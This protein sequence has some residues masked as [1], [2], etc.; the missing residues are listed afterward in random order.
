MKRGFD[1][2]QGSS[3][4]EESSAKLLRCETT[5]LWHALDALKAGDS[6]LWEQ[7][8]QQYGTQRFEWGISE[9][10]LAFEARLAGKSRAWDFIRLHFSNPATQANFEALETY[11]ASFEN[12][13]WEKRISLRFNRLVLASSWQIEQRTIKDDTE[14]QNLKAL[15]DEGLDALLSS[16]SRE[17]R[18]PRPG[19]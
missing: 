12:L 19:S 17:S 9:L 10:H 4:T 14:I 1:D 3:D 11:A 7:I 8:E 13:N 2:V 16:L 15:M 18:A 5:S 6:K